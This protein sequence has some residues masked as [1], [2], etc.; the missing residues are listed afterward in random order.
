M[1]GLIFYGNFLKS[2]YLYVSMNIFQYDF[3][4]DGDY[5]IGEVNCHN[6]RCY[7][8]KPLTATNHMVWSCF[9]WLILPWHVN[10]CLIL[11]TKTASLALLSL[12][13]QLAKL[14]KPTVSH[15]QQLMTSFGNTAKL[16]Q[17]IDAL[18]LDVMS[19]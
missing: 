11:H 2:M 13:N 14:Q 4:C 10:H 5:V 17:L 3:N 15:K 1:I 18:A 6:T 9:R 7:Q 8:K 19:R 16:V 12:A